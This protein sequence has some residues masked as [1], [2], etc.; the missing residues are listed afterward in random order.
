MRII[1]YKVLYFSKIPHLFK[2]ISPNVTQIKNT[3][4]I[5]T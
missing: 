1:E 3:S 4:F 2:I 5:G